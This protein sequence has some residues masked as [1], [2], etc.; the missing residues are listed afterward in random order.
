MKLLQRLPILMAALI[1]LPT[2]A[3]EP[4]KPLNIS[5]IPKPQQISVTSGFCSITTNTPVYFDS[6]F[7]SIAPL[8]TSEIFDATNIKLEATTTQSDCPAIR[9]NKSKDQSL[10]DEGYT[11]VIDQ[12]GVTIEAYA[13]GGAIYALES[14]RQLISLNNPL[15]G[16]REIFLPL[17]TI[18]DQP[19]FPWRGY[20]LDV[21]R[22]FYPFEFLKQT[23]DQMA[24]LKL[25]RFHIHLS[26]DQG[27]RVE[28]IKHPKLNSV[29]S[30]RVDHTNFDENDNSVWGRPVEKEGELAN[31]GGYYTREQLMELVAYAKERNIEILPEIDVPGHSQAIIASYPEYSCEKDKHFTVA[32]GGV[33]GGNTLCP[34]TEAT[35]SFMDDIISEIAEIFPFEYIHIG[36]DE[37]N[38]GQWAKHDQCTQFK[39]DNNLKDDNELQSYFIHRIEEIVNSK[40]RK[41]IG[42]D[43]ILDGG[44][45]PNATVMSWRGESGG[46]AAAKMGHDIIMS[47]NHSNYLDLK[48]GQ[49][50]SEPNLGYSEALISS[51]Y[52]FNIIPEEL[53]EEQGKH[54][55]GNQ[56]NMWTETFSTM[57]AV[58]YMAFPR[59]YAVA[60]NA[61]T[62]QATKSWDGFVERIKSH[63][64]VMDLRGERY[65]KSLFNPWI[66][67]K[68]GDSQVKIWMT[69]EA[70]KDVDIRYTLDGTDPNKYSACYSIGDTIVVD[71]STTIK[72]A[73][74]ENDRPLGDIV[75]RHF[76]IHKAAGAKVIIR[77]AEHPDGVELENN[78]LTDLCYGEFLQGGDTAWM[79]FSEDADIEIQFDEPT[80]VERISVSSV[81]MT[82]GG[83]YAAKQIVVYT[84]VDGEFVEIGDSGVIFGNTDSGRNI[85][86]DIVECPA[87]EV[88]SLRVKVL[89]QATVPEGY[90]PD[91]VG[92]NTS[93]QLD[94]IV[95]F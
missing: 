63:F 52:N 57:K 19:R 92:N 20:M 56:G 47:P 55:L 13:K 68:G 83:T 71:R 93:L 58:S 7:E 39:K 10:G 30:W 60:E 87:E 86:T 46:I 94:E 76:P 70:G 51:T 61:W 24:R 31:Y 40:G 73:V 9:F 18:Q 65:A 80:D 29:G 67:N 90:V 81:R 64:A 35:Y 27:F 82:L 69:C 77:S 62:A 15:W 72:S 85:L 25:N 89:R 1:S 32:T 84:L 8:F 3:Q 74:F 41:M 79:G 48:Q 88:T 38:K 14:L 45:A 50:M 43:E 78:K 37:C 75:T 44:L 34:S 22:T 42:W 59:L 53:T 12:Q 91:M 17:V 49:S 26:D 54:I 36:G 23:V 11:M 33:R 5:L 21:S 95:V 6:Q 2:L 28:M 66:F 4:Q 16:H